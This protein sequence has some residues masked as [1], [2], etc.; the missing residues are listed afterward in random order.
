MSGSDGH[1]R[2]SGGFGGSMQKETLHG[3]SNRSLHS[4]SSTTEG[5]RWIDAGVHPVNLEAAMMDTGGHSLPSARKPIGEDDL[6]PNIN[7]AVGWMGGSRPN[8]VETRTTFR[9][10]K[11]PEPPSP[12]S[13]RGASGRRGG[14]Y[15]GGGAPSP[16]ERKVRQYVEVEAE[17]GPT[18][19]HVTSSVLAVGSKQRRNWR[20][21]RRKTVGN[22][23]PLP[24][25]P[26]PFHSSFKEMSSATKMPSVCRPFFTAKIPQ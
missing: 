22:P 9:D 21:T 20:K 17:S 5:E 19:L 1:F 18:G 15:G 3:S 4:K 8:L 23:P 11:P 6:D 16:P 10:I 7:A 25:H 24:S 26:L 2:H 13:A 14:E 12:L